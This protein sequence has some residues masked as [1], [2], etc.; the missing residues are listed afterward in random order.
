MLTVSICGAT[1]SGQ[2][3]PKLLGANREKKSD[4]RGATG[5]PFSPRPILEI[6]ERHPARISAA[7]LATVALPMP[8]SRPVFR[9]PVTV[10]LR[11]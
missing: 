4:M 11:S 7:I 5:A 10:A 2:P 1:R 8:P 3:L 9:I 6:Y